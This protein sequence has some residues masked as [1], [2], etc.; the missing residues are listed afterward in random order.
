ME[1]GLSWIFLVAILKGDL[2]EQDAKCV[3]GDE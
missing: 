3:S 1:L 2:G